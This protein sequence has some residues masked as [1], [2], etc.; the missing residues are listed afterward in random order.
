VF[1]PKIP[2]S[3]IEPHYGGRWSV[4]LVEQPD[5][6]LQGSWSADKDT[7]VSAS[8]LCPPAAPIPGQPGPRPLGVEPLTFSLPAEGGSVPVAGDVIDGG[9]GFTSVGTITITRD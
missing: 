6:R 4:T 9:D 3:Y 7:T 5:G 1:T 8:V 2:C